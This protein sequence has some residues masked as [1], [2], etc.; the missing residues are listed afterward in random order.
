MDRNRIKQIILENKIYFPSPAQ[1][2]DPFD[3]K[4]NFQLPYS[5]EKKLDLFKKLSKRG[6]LSGLKR[7]QFIKVTKKRIKEGKID[8]DMKKVNEDIVDEYRKKI[9][10]CSFSKGKDNI[11]MWSHYSDGHKG[12]CLEFEYDSKNVFFQ[13]N[14]STESVEYDEDYP[15]LNEKMMPGQPES[16]KFFKIT[17]LTKSTHWSYEG[18]V[19]TLIFDLNKNDEKGRLVPF[20]PKILTGII[21]GCEISE[22]N[23]NY[24]K[25]LIH[26][27]QDHISLYEAKINEKLFKIDIDEIS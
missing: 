7:R 19:R 22:E 26:K 2:N 10:I 3:C 4:P 16:E 20:N 14:T 12:F 11:L 15:T 17:S 9:I 18:E 24:I 13:K 21:L 1:F 23:K 5:K 8:E 25:E 6:G 27:R